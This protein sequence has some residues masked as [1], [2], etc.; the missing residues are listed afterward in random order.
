MMVLYTEAYQNPRNC[1]R[2]SVYDVM[3]DLCHQREHQTKTHEAFPKA[4]ATNMKRTLG[5]SHLE[6]S[7]ARSG[8][9][10]MPYWDVNMRPQA[11]LLSSLGIQASGVLNAEA[12]V[13][14]SWMAKAE[15]A[16]RSCKGA[17]GRFRP[18]QT[19]GLWKSSWSR[20]EQSDTTIPQTF[21]KIQKVELL[22]QF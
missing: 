7:I 2:Y 22:L 5:W 4:P 1:G 8:L 18:L 3:Q 13:A 6:D 10:C 9:M 12:A 16:R 11:Y 14:T 21:R 20:N 15:A 19:Q 17:G